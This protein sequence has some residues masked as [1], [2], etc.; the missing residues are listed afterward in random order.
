[1]RGAT[2]DANLAKSASEVSIHAPHARGDFTST[3]SS[4]F[5]RCFNP[6]PSCEGRQPA[7][8]EGGRRSM[9]Q[10]TPLMRGATRH[11]L[12]NVPC[13][14]VSIHAPHARGDMW[15]SSLRSMARLFQ[16]T[17]LMRGATASPGCRGTRCRV[18]IHAPHARG[19][20]VLSGLMYPAL[21]FN[22]RPSCEGRQRAHRG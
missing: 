11:T 12:Y 2:R 4:S 9:F 20:L 14:N 17:P 3:R 16:S 8:R 21:S 6:R 22:P 1:M 10:S 19:D 7:A 5:Q 15:I 13:V 18:S